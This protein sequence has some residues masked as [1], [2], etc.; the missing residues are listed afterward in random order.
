MH[1]IVE[2]MQIHSNQQIQCNHSGVQE[3]GCGTLWNLAKAS[4]QLAVTQAGGI[5]VLVEALK[6]YL[7]CERASAGL[8]VTSDPRPYYREHLQGGYCPSRW[9]LSR[10][11]RAAGAHPGRWGASAGLH[12]AGEPRLQC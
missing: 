5:A 2:G 8:W 11:C 12:S 3:Q 6:K 1:A 7:E 9:N 4:H 10:C